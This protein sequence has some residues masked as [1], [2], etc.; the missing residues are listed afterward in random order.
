[1]VGSVAEG[2]GRRI[3]RKVT[4]PRMCLRSPPRSTFD[5]SMTFQPGPPGCGA[6]MFSKLPSPSIRIR[7]SAASVS[8]MAAFLLSARRLNLPIAPLNPAGAPEGRGKIRKSIAGSSMPR[9]LSDMTI[10]LLGS[11]LRCL[12][13]MLRLVGPKVAVPAL[14]PLMVVWNGAEMYDLLSMITSPRLSLEGGLK[15]HARQL[16]FS[17]SGMPQLVGLSA[18]GTYIFKVTGHCS[19]T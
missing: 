4:A 13:T 15:R 12:E 8:L 10:P 11:I 1:M 2:S 9:D 5:E 17:G 18:L 16:F 7:T 3:W 19:P 6:S 14:M